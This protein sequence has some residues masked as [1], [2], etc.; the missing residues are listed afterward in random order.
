MSISEYC[1]KQ[2]ATDCLALFAKTNAIAVRSVTDPCMVLLR[3]CVQAFDISRIHFILNVSHSDI[4]LLPR[5]FE[6]FGPQHLFIAGAPS[7]KEQKPSFTSSS[8][9]HPLEAPHCALFISN[10]CLDVRSRET[11][12]LEDHYSLFHLF[13]FI[14]HAYVFSLIVNAHQFFAKCQ[15]HW[16]MQK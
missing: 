12:V 10:L 4:G 7:I 1:C 5:C 8:N 3:N 15:T 9:L 2:V 14:K 11:F 16:E 6:S 13:P